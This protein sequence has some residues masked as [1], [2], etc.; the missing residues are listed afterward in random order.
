VIDPFVSKGAW[1]ILLSGLLIV[2]V[3]PGL[4]RIV[5]CCCNRIFV[6]GLLV[7]WW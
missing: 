6:D 5:G 1:H 2:V 3:W 4:A 7:L